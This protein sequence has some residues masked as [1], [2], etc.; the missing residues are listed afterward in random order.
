MSVLFGKVA[1]WTTYL[2]AGAVLLFGED[3]I[4]PP[5]KTEVYV[6]SEKEKNNENKKHN[7]PDTGNFEQ[8]LIYKNNKD[9]IIFLSPKT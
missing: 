6:Q 3:G 9:K 2:S 5:N 7:L 8:E 1:W 4:L